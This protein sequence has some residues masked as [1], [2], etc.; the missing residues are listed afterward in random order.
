MTD[1]L[2]R[3]SGGVVETAVS[4]VPPLALKA[5]LFVSKS[6]KERY[7]RGLLQNPPQLQGPLMAFVLIMTSDQEMEDLVNLKRKENVEISRL[8]VV[9]AHREEICIGNIFVCTL[10]YLDLLIFLSRT[11]E[12]VN[13]STGKE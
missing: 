7:C 10:T 6:E 2:C 3:G 8:D 9:F 12:R 13:R 1:F 5:Q 11:L 4:V